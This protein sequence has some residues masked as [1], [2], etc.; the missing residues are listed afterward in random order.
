MP[1]YKV[2]GQGVPRREQLGVYRLPDEAFTLIEDIA[3]LS[4]VIA[5]LGKIDARTYEGMNESGQTLRRVH[6][7]LEAVRNQAR[8]RLAREFLAGTPLPK[9]EKQQTL[10]DIWA[11]MKQTLNGH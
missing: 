7:I 4:D 9:R 1:K 11:M 10:A 6:F 2:V 3:R 5:I 8:D